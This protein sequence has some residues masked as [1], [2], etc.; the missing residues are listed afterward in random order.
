MADKNH[1]FAS[2]RDALLS[3]D[4]ALVE[5][6]DARARA[7][8]AL[9][10]LRLRE[11]EA[12]LALP[13]D[14]EVIRAAIERAEAFPEQS[15][16]TVVREVLSASAQMVAP[17][18]V[19][20]LGPAGGFAEAAARQHFGA[21]AELLVVSGVAEVL[22]DVARSRVSFGV[23]PLET[24]SD[25]A[26]TATL[27]GL[28]L[29]D[30]KIRGELSVPASYHLLSSTGNA[31]DIDKVYGAPGALAACVKK[32]RELH[33]KATLL[34][35][36]SGDVAAEFASGDHGAA[37]VGTEYTATVHGLRIVRERIEDVAGIETRFAVIGTDYPTRTGQ[38]RTVVAVSVH[39]EPGA[40]FKALAPFAER[41][42]NL[43][44]LES[45][46]GRGTPYRYVFFV[47][48]DGHLTDRS[49]L[50]AVEELR[51]KSRMLKVL[52]SYP[53]PT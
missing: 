5:A 47:E 40:L 26:I 41:G 4:T 52:G 38:D 17:V 15:L 12:Y 7:I 30:V 25:G 34:D 3:A 39:D 43:T 18:S 2:V 48:F 44:R 29:A 6:L 24:S 9:V 14:E 23:V 13:R 27:T 51:G 21:A 33:P 10:A 37:S 1:D 49:V 45:R 46:P 28:L 53:R 42:I 36:P 19:A 20:Y 8:E 35:V 11:P 22:E 31:S 32:L 50:T 16:T